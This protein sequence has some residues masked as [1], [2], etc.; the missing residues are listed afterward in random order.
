MVFFY[1]GVVIIYGYHG[2]SQV[3]MRVH[4]PCDV[5]VHEG[6]RCDV[7]VHEGL[8]CDVHVHEGLPVMCKGPRD[9]RG[10]PPP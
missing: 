10:S 1:F 4:P 2:Y 3:C 9:V 5:H 7:H 8:R 6:L